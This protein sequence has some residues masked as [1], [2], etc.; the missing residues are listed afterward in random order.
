MYA[1]ITKTIDIMKTAK[2]P[3]A[4]NISLI[5]QHLSGKLNM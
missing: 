1:K 5:L 4:A 2:N 3:A